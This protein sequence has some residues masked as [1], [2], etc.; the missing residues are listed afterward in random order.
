MCIVCNCSLCRTLILRHHA[1]IIDPINSFC[2]SIILQSDTT[3]C[4]V[5]CAAYCRVSVSSLSWEL[6]ILWKRI[7]F[8]DSC[9][10]LLQ[11]RQHRKNEVQ[12]ERMPLDSLHVPGACW[13]NMTSTSVCWG[14]LGNTHP[15]SRSG[16]KKKFGNLSKQMDPVCVPHLFCACLDERLALAHAGG[17][18]GH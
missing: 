8:M 16:S 15:I 5:T 17:L 3:Q 13:I 10:F 6:A 4:A 7:C 9:I 11:I 1:K 18:H 12:S 14:L 2:Q